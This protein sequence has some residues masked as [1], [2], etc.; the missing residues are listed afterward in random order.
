MIIW[1]NNRNCWKGVKVDRLIVARP[2]QVIADM[3]QN[4]Q[5]RYGMSNPPVEVANMTAAKMHG[6]CVRR[7]VYHTFSEMKGNH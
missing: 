3:E 2:V 1:K 7:S 6:V 4:R 5:S